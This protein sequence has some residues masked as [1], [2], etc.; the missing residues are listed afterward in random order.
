MSTYEARL[1]ALR[2]QLKKDQLDGFVVP[3]TDDSAGDVAVDGLEAPEEI[4]PRAPFDLQ[5]RLLA[6]HAG[7][8]QLRLE[9]NGQPNSG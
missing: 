3:L 8:A 4:R 6:D 5:V 1:E 7:T 9:R 2:A